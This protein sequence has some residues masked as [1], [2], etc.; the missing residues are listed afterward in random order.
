[1]TYR[2][3]G[4]NLGD[5]GSDEYTRNVVVAEDVRNLRLAL[6]NALISVR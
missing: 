2:N 4:L 1:V 6:D 5:E 3:E